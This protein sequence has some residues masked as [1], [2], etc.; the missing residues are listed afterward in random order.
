MLHVLRAP[1]SHQAGHTRKIRTKYQWWKLIDNRYDR[2]YG[3]MPDVR[4]TTQKVREI[5]ELIERIPQEVTNALSKQYASYIAIS[6]KTEDY[7]P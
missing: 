4:F 6:E 7:M 5:M 2:A 1:P 3:K